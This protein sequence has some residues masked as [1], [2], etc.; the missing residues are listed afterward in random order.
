M[1]ARQMAKSN[2][3]LRDV[4]STAL[5]LLGMEP[6]PFR[7]NLTKQSLS[8]DIEVRSSPVHGNGVY[9][10]RQF[11]KH[12]LVEMVPSLVMDMSM[13][14]T[15]MFNDFIFGGCTFEGRTVK[16]MGLGFGSVY[17]HHD[18]P[19]IVVKDAEQGSCVPLAYYHATRNV[20][21]GEELLFSYGATYWLSRGG[22]VNANKMLKE[23]THFQK[24]CRVDP[25][26][27]L[28]R[29]NPIHSAAKRRWCG[30]GGTS[31]LASRQHISI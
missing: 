11:K 16:K 8:S 29:P 31:G 28:D 10:T 5:R 20:E 4:F 26:S 13:F 6:P 18:E 27:C 21:E 12:E 17:N 25:K 19:N 15:N 22:E 3:R 30:Y 1:V 24:G 2:V 23:L 14:K 7:I 9:A